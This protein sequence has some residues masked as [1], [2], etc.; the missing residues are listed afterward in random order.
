VRSAKV[1]AFAEVAAELGKRPGIVA[2]R[3]Y[4]AQ[5]RWAVEAAAGELER[6]R[7]PAVAARWM[8]RQ[9]ELAAAEEAAH[10]DGERAIVERAAQAARERAEELR[11][12]RIALCGL[13][14]LPG[15]AAAGQEERQARRR[16]ELLSG[17]LEAH[18]AGQAEALE[19]TGRHAGAAR[20]TRETL[21]EVRAERERAVR[22]VLEEAD[23]ERAQARH[24]AEAHASEAML[25]ELAGA[26]GIGAPH[27]DV[28]GDRVAEITQTIAESVGRQ[29]ERGI[30]PRSLRAPE[31]GEEWLLFVDGIASPA[32]FGSRLEAEA[33]MVRQHNRGAVCTI[34]PVRVIA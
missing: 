1:R 12:E 3:F 33:E 30:V 23:A 16:A 2:S 15:A 27:T 18:L 25:E 11:Q 21:A 9:E 19:R 28:V 24:V 8:A 32:R 31:A 6:D 20:Q 29:A 7:G 17:E 14:N 10:A 22:R 5:E 4:R 13:G 26:A 34:S